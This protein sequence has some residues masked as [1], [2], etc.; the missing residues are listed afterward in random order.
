MRRPGSDKNDP[1]TWPWGLLLHAAAFLPPLWEAARARAQTVGRQ[2]LANARGEPGKTGANREAGGTRG[3]AGAG[4]MAKEPGG[5]A[6]S[7]EISRKPRRAWKQ[8]LRTRGGRARAFCCVTSRRPASPPLARTHAPSPSSR[9]FSYT[10]LL[11]RAEGAALRAV[12]SGHRGRARRC[13]RRRRLRGARRGRDRAE[14]AAGE[15][16]TRLP[17]PPPPARPAHPFAWPSAPFTM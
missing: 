9:P 1:H 6:P 14:T 2:R 5:P 7:V 16:S 11:S 13:R 4:R 15:E 10:F 17:P 12:H 3:G 8:R